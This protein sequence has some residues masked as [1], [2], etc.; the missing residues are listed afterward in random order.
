[1][2]L[3][4]NQTHL[5]SFSSYGYSAFYLNTT[6]FHTFITYIQFN[7]FHLSYV[8]T[9]SFSFTTL[10]PRITQHKSHTIYSPSIHGIRHPSPTNLEF[11]LFLFLFFMIFGLH[12]QLHSPTIN[13]MVPNPYGNIH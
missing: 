3:N 9:Y 2:H 12:S 10:S 7:I 1:M 4:N 11:T 5:F 13:S 6:P 8:K